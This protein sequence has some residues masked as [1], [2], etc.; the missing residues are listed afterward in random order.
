MNIHGNINHI[1][2]LD[3]FRDKY[4]N[5]PQTKFT[6][7]KIIFANQKSYID[8]KAICVRENIEFRTYII[9]FEKKTMSIE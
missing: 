3:V 4:Q 9:S 1:K 8:F 6:K 7:L 2:L 5:A